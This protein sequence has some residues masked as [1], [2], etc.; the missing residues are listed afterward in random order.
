MNCSFTTLKFHFPQSHA[1]AILRI[2]TV[3]FAMG[4][5]TFI[6]LELITV[7][8]EKPDSLCYS[9]LRATVCCLNIMF[10]A[11]QG[12]LIF[13]YPRLNLKINHV[14]DRLVMSLNASPK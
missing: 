6:A 7:I 3:I 14:I 9:P 13:Y 5:V 1:S 8:E 12:F 2:G 10:V 11:L 4:Y